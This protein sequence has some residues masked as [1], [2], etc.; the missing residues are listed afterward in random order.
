MPFSKV[1]TT[2]MLSFCYGNAG[3]KLIQFD[4]QVSYWHNCEFSL[5]GWPSG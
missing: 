2:K 1:K 5:E 3:K 4:S